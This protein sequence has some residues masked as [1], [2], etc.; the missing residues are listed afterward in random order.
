M[1]RFDIDIDHLKFGRRISI[2]KIAASTKSRIV[3]KYFNRKFFRFLHY[4]HTFF[5]LGKIRCDDFCL[6]S[7]FYQFLCQLFQT[8]SSARHKNQRI[9]F[10]REL[11]G[12]FAPDS[13]TCSR[14]HCIFHTLPPPCLLKNNNVILR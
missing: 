4:A 2:G 5:R 9:S 7:I 1:H 3:D 14:Y 13:G 6:A 11:S 12:K 8:F 10:S